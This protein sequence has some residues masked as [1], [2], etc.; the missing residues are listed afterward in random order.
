MVMAV[1][2][3]TVAWTVPERYTKF[4]LTAVTTRPVGMLVPVTLIP[5]TTPAAEVNVSVPTPVVVAVD[6]PTGNVVGFITT[7]FTGGGIEHIHAVDLHL[8]LIGANTK[9]QATLLSKEINYGKNI[10]Q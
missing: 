9:N 10:H 4:P 7:D 3:A 1:P 2:D 8:D 6:K 5:G